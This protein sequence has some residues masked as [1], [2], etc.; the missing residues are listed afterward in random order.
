MALKNVLQSYTHSSKTKPSFGHNE[1]SFTQYC[2]AGQ[3]FLQSNHG[4]VIFK[5]RHFPSVSIDKGLNWYKTLCKADLCGLGGWIYQD[6]KMLCQIRAEQIAN[7]TCTYSTCLLIEKE[8]WGVL[9][10]DFFT[11]GFTNTLKVTTW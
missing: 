6:V 11:Y 4:T 8:S 7:D 2:A 9:P 5:A 1:T 3:P 10:K